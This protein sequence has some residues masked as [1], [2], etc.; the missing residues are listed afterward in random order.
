LRATPLR[1]AT[2]HVEFLIKEIDGELYA[3]TKEEPSM[4]FWYV[5]SPYSKYPEGL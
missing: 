3:I 2:P 1:E 5:A 4:S